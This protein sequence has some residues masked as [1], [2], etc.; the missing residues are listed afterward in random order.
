M[1]KGR[2]FLKIHI[3]QKGDTL[4][5]IAKKYNVDFEL[6]K[7]HNSQLA[8]PD[9]IMPGMKIRIPT[10]PEKIEK[11]TKK[12]ILPK[13]EKKPEAVPKKQ[14]KK[15]KSMELPKM[16]TFP[17]EQ[18]SPLPPKDKKYKEYPTAILPELPEYPKKKEKPKVQPKQEKKP[19]KGPVPQEQYQP[20]EGP[21]YM[22]QVQPMH[23]Q[24][25]MMP[26]ICPCHGWMPMPVHHQVGC[27]CGC[28]GM[29]PQQHSFYG[30]PQ[31]MYPAPYHPMGRPDM[32]QQMM[33]HESNDPPSTLEMPEM[34]PG[35]WNQP[36]Q[37]EMAGN[38][39]MYPAP[40]EGMRDQAQEIQPT[41]NTEREEEETG[42]DD[43]R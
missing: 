26:S 36:N 8:S 37:A 34:Y 7:Q 13:T 3:V 23:P 30:M 4:W 20:C 16:P 2:I 5:E 14:Y 40:A 38:P 24:P 39:P 17:L 27:G 12:Q 10:Q 28:G 1:K 41:P 32:E 19:E 42:N 15:E 22:P 25:H 11:K 21:Y 31:P 6:L 33:G 43:N 9:M 18:E 35:Y 29:H